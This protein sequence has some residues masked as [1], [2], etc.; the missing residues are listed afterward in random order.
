MTDKNGLHSTNNVLH[1][2]VLY[3]LEDKDILSIQKEIDKIF[4]GYSFYPEIEWDA[5]GVS[6]PENHQVMG[7]WRNKEANTFAFLLDN[8]AIY[9]D[10]KSRP[11]LVYI[12]G[13]ERE[14]SFL[15][16]QF[17]ALK[18]NISVEHNAKLWDGQIGKRL[19]RLQKSKSLNLTFTIIGAFTVVMNTASY[20]L[21]SI[22]LPTSWDNNL[23]LVLEI[24][25]ALFSIL[26]ITLLILLVF[27]LIIYTF[28]FIMLLAKR[29]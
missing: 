20:F 3:G 13:N 26:S 9:K 25:I 11:L 27:G 8:P 2:W 29:M 22:I 21:Q 6:A 15:E 28:K 23:I 14:I 17:V 4:S 10:K 12:I 7:A 16:P 1:S 5:Y 18:K 24:F 19:T